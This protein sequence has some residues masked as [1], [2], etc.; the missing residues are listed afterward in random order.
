LRLARAVFALVD[1]SAH[2]THNNSGDDAQQDTDPEHFQQGETAL[3]TAGCS[4]ESGTA[5]CVD[6]SS[7]QIQI[8][9]LR[10]ISGSMMASMITATMAAM[11]TVRVGTSAASIRSMPR[12]AS[13]SNTSAT[14]SS[15]LSSSP[16]C[17]PTSIICSA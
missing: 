17:S 5:H 4:V 12:L 10:L 2:L 6:S 16:A 3:F 9:L 7:V 14:F 11:T 8:W 1:V 13:T 15:M